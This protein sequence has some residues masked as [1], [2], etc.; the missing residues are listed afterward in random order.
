MLPSPS[1]QGDSEAQRVDLPT[2]TG[3]VNLKWACSMP[4]SSCRRL[5][6]PVRW[7][8]TMADKHC[9]IGSGISKLNL[10]GMKAGVGGTPP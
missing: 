9:S 7:P 2:L 3:Q 8:V 5:F 4:A 1:Q 6:C 10:T